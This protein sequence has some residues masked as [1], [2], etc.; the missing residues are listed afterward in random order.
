MQS[1]SHWELK[2]RA[3][4]CLRYTYIRYDF[5]LFPTDMTVDVVPFSLGVEVK[6]GIMSTVI[7]RNSS[8]P[9]LVSRTYSTCAGDQRCVDINVYEG[10]KPRTE[11]NSF[12]GKLEITNIPPAAN[13][14]QTVVVTFCVSV[15]G[16]LSG[17]AAVDNNRI[18]VK[19]AFDIKFHET[20]NDE[21]CRRSNLKNNL[22]SHGVNSDREI[23]EYRERNDGSAEKEKNI[24]AEYNEG[25]KWLKQIHRAD[26]DEILL[27]LQQM[28]ANVYNM[29]KEMMRMFMM[30]QRPNV[31]NVQNNYRNISFLNNNDISFNLFK[32]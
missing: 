19:R 20:D 17:S 1:Q 25:M 8:T 16:I 12:L 3:V 9:A 10:E 28:E 4:S 24:G 14:F 7:E 31:H 6:G 11:Y 29:N 27:H 21:E 15:D 26:K 22:K 18:C 30:N 5:S 32:K 13:G 2:L 23:Q